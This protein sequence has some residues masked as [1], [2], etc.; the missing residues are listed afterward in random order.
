VGP[1]VNQVAAYGAAAVNVQ[2]P[3]KQSVT[4]SIAFSWYFPD[5]DHMNVYVGNYYRNLGVSS[6][7]FI[8]RYLDENA[9][10]KIVNDINTHHYV[11]F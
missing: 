6:E 10:I 9:L 5:R 4:L 2:V 3:P 8:K 11:F 1:F 7:D